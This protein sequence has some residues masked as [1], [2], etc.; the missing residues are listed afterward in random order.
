MKARVEGDDRLAG[1]DHVDQ[2]VRRLNGKID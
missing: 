1:I 2:P